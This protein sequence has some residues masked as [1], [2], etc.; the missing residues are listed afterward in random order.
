[1]GAL[2]TPAT[3]TD[4]DELAAAIVTVATRIAESPA[5]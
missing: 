1:M 3:D 2:A 4:V 5:G